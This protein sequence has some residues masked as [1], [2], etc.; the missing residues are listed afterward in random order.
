MKTR[1]VLCSGETYFKGSDLAWKKFQATHFIPSDA[2]TEQILVT[3]LFKDLS[4]NPD[5]KD[6]AWTVDPL[7]HTGLRAGFRAMTVQIFDKKDDAPRKR[8]SKAAEAAEAM[9]ADDSAA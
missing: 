2:R 5:R 4:A 1:V 7:E 8:A 9:A 3:D 6:P